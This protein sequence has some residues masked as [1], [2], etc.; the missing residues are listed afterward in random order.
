[1]NILKK[2]VFVFPVFFLTTALNAFPPTLVS[3]STTDPLCIGIDNGSIVVTATG[4]GTLQYSIDSGANFQTSNIFSNLPAG[5]YE[6]IVQDGTGISNQ[7]VILNYQKT[8]TASFVPSVISGDAV[9]DV[10]FTNTSSGAIDYNWNLDGANMNSTLTNP[11]FSY[12]IPGIYDVTLIASDNLCRDTASVTINVTGVSEILEIANVFSPNGDGVNDNFFIPCVGIKTLEVFIFNRYG[13]QVYQWSGKHGYW[14]G[15]TYPSA[16]P[17]PDGSYFYYLKAVGFDQI[18]YDIH[19][20]LTLLRI[21][22]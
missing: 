16:Q 11:S 15:H 3:V 1:M 4:T 10:D 12:D 13:N 8:V 9:L 7:T 6:V 14:D 18:E 22:N 5:S 21:T 2:I 17:V 19:G 20:E